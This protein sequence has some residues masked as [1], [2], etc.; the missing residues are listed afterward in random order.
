MADIYINK[1]AAAQRQFDAAVRMFFAQEDELAVL[2]VGYAA[3]GICEDL[4]EK[5]HPGQLEQESRHSIEGGIRSLMEKSGVPAPDGWY[6]K[7]TDAELHAF[8]KRGRNKPPNFLKHA[9][10]DS[11]GLLKDTEVIPD[12]ILLYATSLLIRL[13]VEPSPEQ[14][15]FMTWHLAVYPNEPGDELRTGVE[16]DGRRLCIHELERWEQKE[17][18]QFILELHQPED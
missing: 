1:L 15:A 14:W 4:F 13:K 11:D 17:A 3:L 12:A 2:T 18:G 6:L 7:D 8:F 9:N 16:R 10:R 5:R